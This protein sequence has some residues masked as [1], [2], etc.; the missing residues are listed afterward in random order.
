MNDDSTVKKRVDW[1]LVI[2][3]PIA[4]IAVL[5]LVQGFFGPPGILVAIVGLAVFFA[6]RA[7]ILWYFR[8]NAR[9]DAAEETNDLL[10]ELLAVLKSSTK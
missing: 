1:W 10:R 6:V 3:V 9:L 8:I 7:L 5:A 2:G 4:I